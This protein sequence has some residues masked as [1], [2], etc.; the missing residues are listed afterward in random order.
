MRL[1]SLHPKHLDPVGLVALWREGLLAKKVI[2]GS[3]R[4]YQNHPQLI[5]FKESRDPLGS[6]NLYLHMIVDEAQRRKYNFNRDKLI[7]RSETINVGKLAIT[8][9][10]LAYER[11]HLLNKLQIRNK[12]LFKVLYQTKAT[13]HPLFRIIKGGVADWE[14]AESR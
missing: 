6:I 8:N 12:P 3:T 2:E 13:Q 4:G 14:N 1:W 10:Q 7:P 11:E 9:G 5:R